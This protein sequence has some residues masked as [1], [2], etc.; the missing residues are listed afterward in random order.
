MRLTFPNLVAFSTHRAGHAKF[1]GLVSKRMAG[2]LA[3]T[4]RMTQNTQ[5]RPPA[6]LS[7][8]QHF[9]YDVGRH[10]RLERPANDFTIEQI[11]NDRQLQPTFVGP[12]LG[13][14]RRPDEI[15]DTSREVAPQKILRH[16]KIMFRVC[17]NLV[18]PLVAGTNAVLLHKSF[19]TFLA[20]SEALQPQLAHYIRTTVSALEL[21]LDGPNHRQHLSVLQP[22][23]P[24][25]SATLPRPLATNTDIENASHLVVPKCFGQRI[26]P[27][28][29]HR[30]SLVKYAAAF[31]AISFSRLSR[32][33]STRNR[34]N[35]NA[36]GLTTLLPASASLHAAVALIKL[37][38]V[39][40]RNIRSM[41]AA[42]I[43]CPSERQLKASSLN[44]VLCAGFGVFSFFDTSKVSLFYDTDGRLNFRVG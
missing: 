41:A 19:N 5:S 28:V 13:D 16:R 4:S 31:F 23:T 37:R 44:T 8:R 38:N 40:S 24:R 15:G 11:K 9:Y 39:W 10:K 6:E 1:L 27:D 2:V 34:D 35:S 26:N 36:S 43:A 7:H 33:T 32:A 22:L 25:C 3:T 21:C 18:A 42:A 14:V 12:E 30:I 17:C 29:F 20:R